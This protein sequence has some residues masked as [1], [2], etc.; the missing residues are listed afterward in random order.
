[1]IS[2]KPILLLLL[3]ATALA[4]PWMG[5]GLST[6]PQLSDFLEQRQ[7]ISE[8]SGP[9]VRSLR[10][11][12]RGISIEHSVSRLHLL[13][14]RRFGLSSEHSVRREITA[15]FRKDLTI[16]ELCTMLESAGFDRAGCF[17]GLFNVSD[18]FHENQADRE[19]AN[20]SWYLREQVLHALEA[21]PFLRMFDNVARDPNVPNIIPL[22]ISSE[23]MFSS[24]EPQ[25]RLVQLRDKFA[26]NG[27]ILRPFITLPLGELMK[28]RSYQSMVQGPFN[29]AGAL[30][31]RGWS[32]GVVISG[33]RYYSEDPLLLNTKPISYQNRLQ[34]CVDLAQERGI[35]IW[36]SGWEMHPN[37]A[38]LFELL[39]KVIRLPSGV[40]F[41]LSLSDRTI[42]KEA[43][44]ILLLGGKDMDVVVDPLPRPL[45]SDTHFPWQLLPHSRQNGTL[46]AIEGIGMVGRMAKELFEAGIGAKFRACG[47]GVAE[48][49]P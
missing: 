28:T 43:A 42:W 41:L 9:L 12:A 36:F 30:A 21:G 26:R 1:M 31:A 8:M 17:R 6:L 35:P 25:Q 11:N 44:P 7:A 32:T 2:A 22:P 4:T 45:T 29:F 15:G 40:R 13:L 47:V 16:G 23:W 10:G 49:K 24:V 37:S 48:S 46:V 34:Y 19:I 38:Y 33:S 18:W 27:K 14:E 20:F 5:D 39:G 3:S